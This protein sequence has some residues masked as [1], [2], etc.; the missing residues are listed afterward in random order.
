MHTFI[1][2]WC[3]SILFSKRCSMLSAT[4]PFFIIILKVMNF[5]TIG[6]L[7]YLLQWTF[8]LNF[9]KK[10][11]Y[12]IPVLWSPVKDSNCFLSID[13][14]YDGKVIFNGISW[15]LIMQSKYPG[16]YSLVALPCGGVNLPG[17]TF[18]QFPHKICAW[19]LHWM[20]TIFSS[21]SKPDSSDSQSLCLLF[22]PFLE[23]WSFMSNSYSKR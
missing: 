7:S 21:S 8:T 15:V 23:S 6:T 19:R 4:D 3:T 2:G 18:W 20:V 10:V 12:D 1:I 13:S 17:K 22:V 9:S 11:G 14:K 5:I 16:G